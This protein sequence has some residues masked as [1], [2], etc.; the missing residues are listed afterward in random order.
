MALGYAGQFVFVLPE[1]DLVV[2]FVSDLSE[3]DFYVPQIL[4]MDYIIP[5]INPSEPILEEPETQA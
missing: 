1:E 4:L 3:G 2:V 5:A